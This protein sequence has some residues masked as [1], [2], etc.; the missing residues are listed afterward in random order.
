MRVLDEIVNLRVVISPSLSEDNVWVLG[1]Q[2][3]VTAASNHAKERVQSGKIVPDWCKYVYTRNIKVDC[4]LQIRKILS[5]DHNAAQHS[6]QKQ[7][8]SN[9]IEHYWDG[10]SQE[11]M[12]PSRALITALRMCGRLPTNPKVVCYLKLL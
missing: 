2:H 10:V 11:S 6:T 9:V 3:I 5:G 4:P 12:A 8:I 1:G 7:S